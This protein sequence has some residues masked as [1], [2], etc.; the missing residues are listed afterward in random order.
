MTPWMV[1]GILAIALAAAPHGAPLSAQTPTPRPTSSSVRL[2]NERPAS[3]GAIELVLQSERLGRHYPV[4]VTPP[5][6]DFAARGRKLPAIYVLDG[7]YGMAGAI[8]QFLGGVRMMSLAYVVS[9]GA[10]NA[11]RIF[12]FVDTPIERDGARV[13]GGGAAFRDFLLHELRPYL[14][15]RFPLDAGNSALFGHSLGG[16]FAA[17]VLS[18]SPDA[19]SAYVIGSPALW[20]DPRLPT[21]LAEVVSKGSKARVY[22]SVGEKE[23]GELLQDFERLRAA[24]T[25]AG[26]AFSVQTRVFAGET[27]VSYLPQLVTASFSWALPPP[28][29]TPARTALSLPPEAL[30]RVVGVYELEDGRT[31]TITRSGTQIFSQVSTGLKAPLL[32]ETP[33]TF[34]VRGFDYV[35]TFES[36]DGALPTGLVLRMNGAEVR[37]RR[38]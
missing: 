23:G 10:P 15:S 19:F 24:V 31:V 5:S 14:E 7:G 22:L 29:A 3:S 16:A 17:G 30:D 11:D 35:V 36:P 12:D 21:V 26:S 25:A 34:F 18:R 37:A 33:S 38:R 8:G 6:G 2:V 20:A 1:L 4:V 28:A 13:G 27:H 32:A 9:V